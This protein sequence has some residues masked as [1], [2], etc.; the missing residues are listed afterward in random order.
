VPTFRLPADAVSSAA[1]TGASAPLCLTA[2][3]P[4]NITA[5]QCAWTKLIAPGG[6]AT[7]FA[8]GDRASPPVPSE[9]V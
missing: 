1:D 7:S 9:N 6:A 5:E 2:F 3:T 4:W 8:I